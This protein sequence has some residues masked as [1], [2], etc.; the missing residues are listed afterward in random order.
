M[1][2]T[3]IVEDNALELAT[4][5]DFLAQKCPQ[6]EVVGTAGEID[7]AYE[8]IMQ[9]RPDLLISDIQLIGGLCYDLLN[10]LKKAGRLH[11]LR[12]IFM[13]SFRDFDNAKNGYEYSPIAFLEK[14]FTA[15]DLQQAV[16][17]VGQPRISTQ[18]H[19][20]M[21]LFLQYLG[22]QVAPSQRLTVTL[23]GGT[24]QLVDLSEVVYLE[25]DGSVTHF[26][27][28]GTSRPL[29]SSKSLGYY[30]GVLQNDSRFFSISRGILINMDHFEQYDHSQLKV[31]FKSPL[32]HVYASREGGKAL[33]QHLLQNPLP[34]SRPPDSVRAFFRRLFGMGE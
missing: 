21:E 34:D 25:A 30:Q 33:R 14:P 23:V 29:A 13:T 15:S 22:Q 20:Q 19:E 28:K 17:K 8:G 12:I 16:E 6:T 31:Q 2:K 18:A 9:A 24:M 10:R 7:E 26:Y 4:V 3:Y 27:L 11:D 5:V 1:L 32:R